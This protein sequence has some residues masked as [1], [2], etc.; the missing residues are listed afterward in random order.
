MT[1]DDYPQWVCADC[2]IEWGKHAPATMR[3]TWHEDICG[4][5]G[6]SKTC[7]EPRDF[8]HLR[9]GWKGSRDFWRKHKE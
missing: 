7:T 5:C 1:D 9:S 6:R 8:G 3:A 2:G 4:I